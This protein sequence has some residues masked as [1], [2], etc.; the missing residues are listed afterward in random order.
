[1]G[2]SGKEI[3]AQEIT[4]VVYDTV[5][6]DRV[7]LIPR[8]RVT[9]MDYWVSYVAYFCDIYFR[10]SFDIIEEHDY[11]NKIIDRI[12]YSNPDTKQKWENIRT[13]LAKYIHDAPGVRHNYNSLPSYTM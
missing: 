9:E 8:D 3:G 4:P 12:P 1:M 10:A 6:K 7:H 5:L 2:A 13:H 11:L